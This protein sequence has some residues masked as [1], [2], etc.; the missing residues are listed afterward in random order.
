MSKARCKGCGKLMNTGSGCTVKQ[1]EIGDKS[2]E[3]R[4]YEDPDPNHP[5]HDCGVTVGQ[6][7]HPGCDWERCPKCGGQAIMCQAVGCRVN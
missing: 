1:I 7:H 4:K 6:L 5:C 3:R 2:Y